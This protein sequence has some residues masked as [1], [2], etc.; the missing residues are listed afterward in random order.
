MQYICITPLS[1][2]INFV[3]VIYLLVIKNKLELLNPGCMLTEFI[4]QSTKLIHP[5]TSKPSI[6]KEYLK[7]TEMQP[8]TAQLLTSVPQNLLLL[9]LLIIT[10]DD[11][12]TQYR[13]HFYRYIRKFSLTQN[14]L[15]HYIRI[16]S[17][18]T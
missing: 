9:I 18:T 2:D 1:A 7:G 13:T 5:N 14:N 17:N 3:V 6:F 10:K 11:C 8:P 4:M 12:R 15:L 16:V